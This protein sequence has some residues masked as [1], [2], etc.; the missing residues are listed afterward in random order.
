M[1]GRGTFASGN[2]VAYTYETVGTI[3]GIKVLQGLHGKHNLPE[4]SHSGKAYILVSN[5]GEFKR[6]R[7]Y[8]KNLTSAFDI[9]YHPEPKISG[10][11]DKV[12]HI[13]FYNNG[14]RDKVG[15][16][17]TNNEYKKYKKYFG[18]LTK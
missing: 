2:N 1:G 17:L 10:N 13:H 11:Y 6:Y 18:G 3:E 14:V 8:D 16:L 4:E 5:T 12:Y 15:R 9:D 7:A